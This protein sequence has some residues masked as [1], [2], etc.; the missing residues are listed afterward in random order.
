MIRPYKGIVPTLGKNAYVDEQASVIGDVHLGEDASVWPMASLRGDVN[1]IR[2]GARSNV[3]DNAVL[4]VT[5]DGPYSPGGADL[6][7]GDDVTIA[8][9]VVL[10]ACHIGDRVLIGMGSIVMDKVEIEHDVIVAAGSLVTPG[11]RLKS[12]WLYAGRPAKPVRE[13]K[14]EEIENFT[15][16]TAHYVRVKNDYLS[17][18]I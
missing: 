10:H 6:I 18:N 14:A 1:R 12:G 7:I 15:Y 17:G 3:Q 5:H 2:V 8:H 4:H 9:A 11:K 13:L 16:S